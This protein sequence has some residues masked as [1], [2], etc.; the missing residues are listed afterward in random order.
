VSR[1]V[2]PLVRAASRFAL[3]WAGRYTRDLD[4][5][6]AGDRRD[7][8]ASDVW[9][10]VAGQA[11][12]PA[13]A[14]AASIVGRVLRG[15]P[16]DLAW[17]WRMP[18]GAPRETGLVRIGLA[19]ALTVSGAALALGVGALVRT[20]VGLARGEALPSVVTVSSTAVGVAA[21]VLGLLLVARLR[22]RR[23]GLLWLAV[24]TGVTL[25][26]GSLVLVTLSATFQ[27]AFYGLAN[28]SVDAWLPGWFLVVGAISAVPALIS[29]TL[30]PARSAVP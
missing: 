19:I 16:A 25:H 9:E 11:D 21:L 15:I 6:I 14:L 4:P 8:I 22:T 7:E 20:A 10:Q 1:R 3:S 13:A 17:R 27:A 18:S 29:I 2:A 24:A 12:R 30:A 28:Y 5:V 26:F 23:L